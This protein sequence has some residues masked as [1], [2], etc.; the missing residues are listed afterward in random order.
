M[1]PKPRD[2]KKEV[3]QRKERQA[4]KAATTGQP[5]PA[6]QPPP[7]KAA[8]VKKE[9]PPKTVEPKKQAEEQVMYVPTDCGH[10]PVLLSQI[11]SDPNQ[12]R[13]FF[14]AQKL[15]E[16]SQS[17]VQ[18]DVIEPILIRPIAGGLYMVVFG[19]R[20]FRASLMAAEAG[21][22][23]TT[24]PAMIKEMSNDEALEYQFAENLHRADPHPIEDA[25]TFKKMLEKH[26]VEEI[27]L[28]V[29]KSTKFVAMRMMLADLTPAFQEVFF[30]NKMSLG[31]AVLLCKVNAEGQAAIYDDEVPDDWKEDEDFM[32]DDIK[33]LVNRESKNLDSAP[34]KTED[35]DLYPEM[36]SCG[37][38]PF[39]S[40][41]TLQLFV[42]EQTSRICGNAV[43]FNIKCARAYKQSIEKVMADP[44]VVFVAAG[45]YN[46][47]DKQKVKDVEK[48]GVQV[49]P[50]GT[51]RKV[52]LEKPDWNKH[53]QDNEE[54]FE[55][56]DETRE[57]FEANVKEEYD[58]MLESYEEQVKEYETAKAEGKIRKAFVVAGN[59]EG[60]IVDIM[61][62]TIQGEIALAGGASGDLGK[63]NEIAEI[64]KREKRNKEL[65][66]EKVW[67]AT[68]EAIGVNGYALFLNETALAPVERAALAAVFYESIGWQE[69]KEFGHE[70]LKLKDHDDRM[71]V[72]KALEVISDGNF[73]LLCRIFM[74]QKLF[75]NMGSHLVSFTNYMGHAV[76]K[77]YM[78]GQITEIETAQSVKAKKRAETVKKKIKD[79]KD[80]PP[81][82]EKKGE[83]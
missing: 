48:L 44:G 82:K 43:C 3:Q 25:F 4:A 74:K 19:E 32:L 65:D 10:I 16:L 60:T 1:A 50:A 41:N 8:P 47:E 30:A 22:N 15:L 64:N 79:L 36:G 34:F 67:L 73:N 80:P 78:P 18:Y 6:E 51:W 35:P 40:A 61:P 52:A 24:I 62:T 21:H 2:Y 28:R 27:A 29:D 49:L 83:E 77:H 63:S 38:C 9:S 69:R 58:G 46:N 20:R 59:G 42:E 75:P 39:N 26:T 23:I 54:N 53:L 11:V 7:K 68:R 71:K 70:V 5:A 14:D 76:A 66:S 55:A 81:P 13:K 37:K 12:P 33:H 17:I 45:H 31:Q 56:E 72:A 57:Q